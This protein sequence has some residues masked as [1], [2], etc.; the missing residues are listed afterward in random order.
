[1]EF[2]VLATDGKARYGK[3]KGTHGETET[4]CFMPVGTLGAVKGVTWNEIS[5]MGYSLVLSNVYH[6]YLRPG[7]E[8]IEK[9]GGLHR[10]VNWNGL[11]LTDSGGFQVFSLGKLMK[12]SEE[13][14]YF[15][16]HI[17]GSEHF[18]SPELV[19]ELEEKMGVDIGMVLD[20]CTPYP[21]TYEYAK[22][23]MER[24]VRWA[25]RSIKARTTDK[26]AIFGIVQ[27]GTYD[28]LRLKCVELLKGLPFEG[29]AI[30]GLSVGEPKEEMYRITKL[31]AP[32]L[33]E[34]KPR[35]LMGVGKPEDIIEA[36]E[37][38]V[39]MFDCVIPTRN[40]R[41]GT[42]FTSRGKVNIKSAKYKNDFSPLD[43]ECDCYTCR[44]FTKAYLR[45]LYVSKEINSAIL[46]TIHNLYFYNRLM[47]KMREAIKNGEFQEFKKEF[48][49]KY[50]TF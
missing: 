23:S 13:G 34:E 39:D 1:M 22:H 27:G 28:D 10:F 3:L 20:E 26:T 33:P 4:P 12:I 16:S 44:N 2:K 35:Y 45:H 31:V 43:P 38:G 19:V 47:K 21:A 25:L 40:A 30:G 8:V 50:L 42:L 6:L 24:T 14:I 32:T 36:V 9:A 15:K 49:S 5:E 37:A 46:N 17:D 29:F 48:F 18:F 11:I 41:N 7:I